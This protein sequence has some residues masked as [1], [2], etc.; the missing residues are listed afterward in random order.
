MKERPR[1]LLEIG[2]I[3]LGLLSLWPWTLGY[4]AVWYQIGLVMILVLLGGLAVV[5]AR[6]V[7]QALEP[8]SISSA[9]GGSAER[10]EVR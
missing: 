9:A 5:R 4:R 7:R 10:S 3:L 8:G 2:I 1:K 6:R